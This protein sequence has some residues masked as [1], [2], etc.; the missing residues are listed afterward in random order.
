MSRLVVV[1]AQFM[2]T[3]IWGTNGFHLLDL[4]PSQCRV[5]TQCFVEHVMAPLVQTVFP[6]GRTRHT[7][8]LNVHLN[9]CCIHFSKVMEQ[10][11]IENQLLHV[12][13]PSYGPDWASSDFWPFWLVKTGLAGR[14]FAEPE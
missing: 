3:A 11:F 6:Q 14:N 5:N 2:L 9:G 8:R 12:V 10:F 1:T 13:H 7:P 4:M